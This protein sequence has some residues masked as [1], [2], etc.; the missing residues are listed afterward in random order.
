MRQTFHSFCLQLSFL[1]AL[2]ALLLSIGTLANHAPNP[3]QVWVGAIETAGFWGTMQ[4]KVIQQGEL[5]KAESNF[6]V[7]GTR[8]SSFVHNLKI[9][10]DTMSFSTEVQVMDVRF[11]LH[12]DGK[13]YGNKL[14]GVVSVDRDDRTSTTGTWQLQLDEGNH[15]GQAIIEL[16]ALTGRSL[17]LDVRV[18]RGPPTADELAQIDAAQ[19]VEPLASITESTTQHLDAT[20]ERQDKS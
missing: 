19:T 7:A 1:T 16:P 20:V 17:S 12:F 8:V 11:A 18:V 13:R 9:D 15:P 6:D 2:S 5:W 10:G 4:L 14:R 3:D